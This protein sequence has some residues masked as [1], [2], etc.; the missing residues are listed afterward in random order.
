MSDP[1]NLDIMEKVGLDGLPHVGVE[2]NDG[3][4]YYW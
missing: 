4:P 2:L 3:D 1:T